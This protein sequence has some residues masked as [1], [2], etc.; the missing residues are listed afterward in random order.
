MTGPP[1][2]RRDDTALCAKCRDPRETKGGVFMSFVAED[3]SRSFV[4]R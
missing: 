3:L 2:G 1:A 4:L